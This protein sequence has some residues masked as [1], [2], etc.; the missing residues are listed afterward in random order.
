MQVDRK[1]KKSEKE[2]HLFVWFLLAFLVGLGLRL[3][4]LGSMRFTLAEAQIAQSAWQMAIGKAT[5]L[6]GN[7]SYA[8][9]SALLF[10]LFEPSFFFARLMPALFGSSLILV[11]WFWR[12]RIGKK[13]ALLLAIGLAI[14]PILSFR[15]KL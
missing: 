5:E 3:W 13:A 10:T 15:G 14:D 6:P 4:H 1:V 8:G 12:D 2:Q 9:L 7:M 11:P